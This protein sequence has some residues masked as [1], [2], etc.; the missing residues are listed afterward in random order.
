[1]DN[2]NKQPENQKNP[3]E[4]KTKTD[5]DLIRAAFEEGPDLTVSEEDRIRTRVFDEINDPDQKATL[6]KAEDVSSPLEAPDEPGGD[7]TEEGE[8]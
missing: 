6:A 2:Q 8:K 3:D 7:Q 5:F 1:M 4:P